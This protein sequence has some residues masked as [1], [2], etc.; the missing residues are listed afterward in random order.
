M[1]PSGPIFESSKVILVYP[2][3]QASGINL[4]KWGDTLDLPIFELDL[5]DTNADAWKEF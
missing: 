5:N 3:P 4:K 1:N 2:D